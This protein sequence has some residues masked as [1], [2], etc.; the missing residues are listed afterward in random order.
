MIVPEL[1]TMRL[2]SRKDHRWRFDIGVERFRRVHKAAL[3]VLP[4]VKLHGDVE[5]HEVRGTDAATRPSLEQGASRRIRPGRT[6]RELPGKI[7]RSGGEL[8]CRNRMSGDAEL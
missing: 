7:V 6:R 5:H 2:P 3:R 1:Q 8:G 4:V